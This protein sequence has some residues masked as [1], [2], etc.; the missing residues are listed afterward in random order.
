MAVGSGWHATCTTCASIQPRGHTKFSCMH[1]ARHR[2][3]DVG[4]QGEI[5][6]KADSA[7]SGP[8]WSCVKTKK[9]GKIAKIW[10]NRASLSSHN[11]SQNT[12]PKRA[13]F[14]AVGFSPDF[15]LNPDIRPV[16]PRNMH[17]T[18]VCPRGRM[19]AHVV[20]TWHANRTQPP[21]WLNVKFLKSLED[22]TII[23]VCAA[24]HSS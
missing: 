2:R 11:I 1:I 4:A 19:E 18:F 17:A 6:G 10:K 5:G 3:S 7:K 14:C 12:R 24:D 15:T 16:M 23:L 9:A 21:S 20:H 13:R 22:T 8:P